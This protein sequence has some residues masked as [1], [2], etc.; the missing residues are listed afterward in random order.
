M[1]FGPVEESTCY[2]QRV[3]LETPPNSHTISFS[4]E[5]SSSMYNYQSPDHWHFFFLF[6]DDS[7]SNV[8]WKV[9]EVNPFCEASESV[10]HAGD[11][12]QAMSPYDT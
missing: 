7:L 11:M 9:E 5:T 6:D 8:T 3:D 2:S 4:L 10:V 12:K 1:L